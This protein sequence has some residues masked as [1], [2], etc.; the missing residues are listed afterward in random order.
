MKK[1][2]SAFFRKATTELSEINID[3]ESSNNSLKKHQ[4]KNKKNKKVP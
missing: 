3:F 4:K 2:A 1:R